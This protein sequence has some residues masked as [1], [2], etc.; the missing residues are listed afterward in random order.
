MLES[1]QI[2][3]LLTTVI[4][5]G[6][7]VLLAYSPLPRSLGQAIAHRLMHGKEP[8]DA[9]P[10]TDAR[11]EAMADEMEMLR[12]QLDETQG[13]LDFAERMLTQARE[14]GALGPGVER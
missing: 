11:L 9:P 1:Y 12:R 14:R 3:E 6:V 8:R 10:V 5:G 2:T 13:R 7:L 4:I